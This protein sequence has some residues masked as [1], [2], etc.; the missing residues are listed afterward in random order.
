ML[1]CFPNLLIFIFLCKIYNN[2]HKSYAKHKDW[3]NPNAYYKI[4]KAK[5]KICLNELN[6]DHIVKSSSK[7]AYESSNALILPY[8]N[9]CIFCI[10][11]MFIT[12]S[13]I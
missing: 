6:A 7:S 5:G 10:L 3:Q 2:Y 8:Y 11:Y 9:I 1:I 12:F 13:F 4:F